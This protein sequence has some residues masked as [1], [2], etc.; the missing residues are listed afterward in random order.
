M[1]VFVSPRHAFVCFLAVI[2]L[3]NFVSKF[4]DAAIILEVDLAFWLQVCLVGKN[5]GV[6]PFIHGQMCFSVFGKHVKF[7]QPRQHLFE[8]AP[9]VLLFCG[10][11]PFVVN[12]N[13]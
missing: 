11:F 9:W 5:H 13:R 1:G 12:D 7:V 3:P 10:I 4:C 2:F 8:K 6:K